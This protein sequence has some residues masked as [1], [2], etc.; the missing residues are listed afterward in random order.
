MTKREKRQ[1]QLSEYYTMR[2]ENSE[3]E[4]KNKPR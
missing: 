2:D 1:K 3:D 4:S